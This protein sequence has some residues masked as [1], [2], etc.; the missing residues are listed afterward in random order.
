MYYR[1]IV[2]LFI[3]ITAI[4]ILASP[5]TTLIIKQLMCIFN[6]S[7]ALM[8]AQKMAPCPLFPQHCATYNTRAWTIMSIRGEDK[9]FYSPLFVCYDKAAL[10]KSKIKCAH[11][12][13]LSFFGLWSSA[14]LNEIADKRGLQLRE[15]N[16]NIS[17]WNFPKYLGKIFFIYLAVLNIMR[18]FAS[19]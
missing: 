17:L 1:S 18:N 19:V 12:I 2:C 3:T 10:Y 11:V 4:E 14:K 5:L 13:P 9:V 8:C 7:W 15:E 6:N 16:F